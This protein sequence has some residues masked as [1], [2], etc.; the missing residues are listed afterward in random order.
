[1]LMTDILECCTKEVR[2]SEVHISTGISFN[3][4]G[5][6]LKML[7]NKGLL[8]KIIYTKRGR[9]IVPNYYT[10]LISKRGREFLSGCREFKDIYDRYIYNTTII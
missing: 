7:L 3:V 4:M 6:Y 9:K 5:R 1:M 8:F 10:L 2:Y